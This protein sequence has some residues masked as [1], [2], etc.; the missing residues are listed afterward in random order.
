M[1]AGNYINHNIPHLK[2]TDSADRALDMME[3]FKVSHLPVVFK[4][5]YL[6]ILSESTLMNS[7]DTF[8]AVSQF[9]LEFKN[10][11]LT[12][13]NYLYDIIDVM[14]N[15]KLSIVPIINKNEVFE[16]VVTSDEM[17]KGLG[18]LSAVKSPGTIIE[19]LL[20]ST[21]YSLAEI[22]R[23]IESNG[24]KILSS[25]L[26][27]YNNDPNRVLLSIKLNTEHSSAVLAALER[28]Q[29]NII[30]TFHDQS[31]FNDDDERLK[32]FF[33]YLNT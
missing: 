4:D 20:K 27:P 10:I 31:S 17:I 6:G 21:D 16:G 15:N 1:V 29:Y 7:F 18:E 24:S 13:S 26:K 5:Q 3:E 28:F 14:V 19:I 11:S 9:P 8:G 2:P 25:L 23:I 22:S 12:P 33:K 30:S 32:H